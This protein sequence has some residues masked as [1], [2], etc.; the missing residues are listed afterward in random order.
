MLTRK[1]ANELVGMLKA[2]RS[3]AE[4]AARALL[5]FPA[6]VPLGPVMNTTCLDELSRELAGWIERNVA[7]KPIPAHVRGLWL[8][9]A[10]PVVLL[11]PHPETTRGD[12]WDI[13]DY[14]ADS[15]PWQP[16]LLDVLAECYPAGEELAVVLLAALLRDFAATTPSSLTRESAGDLMLEVRPDCAGETITVGALGP[17]GFSLASTGQ[18]LW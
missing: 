11:Q 14:W 10:L 17:N 13:L 7:R 1:S 15:D 2:G 16:A 12:D 18:N 9:V 3:A 6:L 8:S 4:I 5:E